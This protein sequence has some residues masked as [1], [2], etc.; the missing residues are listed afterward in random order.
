MALAE[1]KLG[2]GGQGV[3]RGIANDGLIGGNGGGP[4][5]HFLGKLTGEVTDAGRIF[6]AGEIFR[7]LLQHLATRSQ[8][9][10]S[11]GLPIQRQVAL[12]EF[13]MTLGN[14]EL[15]LHGQLFL[16]ENFAEGGQ[17]SI[18]SIGHG[19]FRF[20]HQLSVLAGRAIIKIGH[21]EFAAEE[22][23]DGWIRLRLVI[24]LGRFLIGFQ[25][26]GTREDPAVAQCF[27]D[28]DGFLLALIVGNN[29]RRLVALFRL[30]G[31]GIR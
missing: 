10:G 13:E 28:S 3:F 25:R 23:F 17:F 26:E 11:G 30:V 1:F 19:Y 8:F 20:H 31:I 5:L 21:V 29:D 24:S 27:F 14:G 2:I 6:G 16:I 7:Q 22:S 9:N 18:R 4:V 15:R 12:E